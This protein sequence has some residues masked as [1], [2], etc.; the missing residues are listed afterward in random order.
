MQRPAAIEFAIRCTAL[1]SAPLFA[2]WSPACSLTGH[3]QKKI[4]WVVP[5][6]PAEAVVP[7]DLALAG[8]PGKKR[9]QEAGI[10][11]STTLHGKGGAIPRL[12]STGAG[13]IDIAGHQIL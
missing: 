11:G 6:D 4:G 8:R 5:E 13:S 3:L 12:G 7:V 9:T 1:I 10:R 2:A